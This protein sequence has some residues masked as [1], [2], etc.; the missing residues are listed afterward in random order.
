MNIY[1][2]IIHILFKKNMEPVW[3]SY[4]SNLGWSEWTWG[5]PSKMVLSK[6][7][8]WHQ[9]LAWSRWN[10]R[11]TNP[12]RCQWLM[13]NFH[14]PRTR[15]GG[16]CPNRKREDVRCLRLLRSPWRKGEGGST[17]FNMLQN[18]HIP[19]SHVCGCV[20]WYVL[21]HGM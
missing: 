9:I 1:I 3:T 14:P 4:I 18:L 11:R 12:W 13:C 15:P 2:Y 8:W 19:T 20:M 7:T 10:M 5:I 6:G 16:H 21:R 17:Y